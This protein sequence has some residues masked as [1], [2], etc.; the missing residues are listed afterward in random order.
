LERL[1]VGYTIAQWLPS[2][3]PVDELPDYNE[4]DLLVNITSRKYSSHPEEL[5]T[6]RE[7]VIRY[8]D[9]HHP[10]SFSL[11]G[12]YWNNRHRPEDMYHHGRVRSR[13]Y[14]SYGGLIDDKSD[15]YRSH[16]FALCFE[17]VTGIDGYLTEKLF[18]C[19]RG[20][21]VPVY[22][23][24]ENVT[25]YVPEGAFVDY[26]E[27]GCPAALHEH[28]ISMDETTWREMLEAG[29]EF[30]ESGAEAHAPET[31][32][33]TVYGAVSAAVESESSPTSSTSLREEIS[34]RG[35]LDRFEER[36]ASVKPSSVPRELWNVAS[37]NPRLL[38]EHPT[39]TARAV[40]RLVPV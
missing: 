11:Y 32:A 6:A 33:E 5:Y 30:F 20:G 9:E 21:T 37:T 29:R 3:G 15:A 27:F 35:T 23:G 14:S 12:R 18:D 38:V 2:L 24:A 40:R 28:L 26:R 8:Y 25:E 31:Y 17:N 10:D 7:A 36:P 1:G 16:R 39:A 4:R 22:W 34:A 13:T 19:L